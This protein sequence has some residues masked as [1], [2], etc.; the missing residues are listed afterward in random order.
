MVKDIESKEK[1]PTITKEMSDRVKSFDNLYSDDFSVFTSEGCVVSGHYSLGYLFATLARTLTDRKG[2]FDSVNDSKR[3]CGD[4][5]QWIVLD[6]DSFIVDIPLEGK[7]FVRF[8]NKNKRF[9]WILTHLWDAMSGV[10]TANKKVKGCYT[11]A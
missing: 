7:G 6:R 3:L 11:I 5:V 9:S 1:L 2:G 8:Y 10:M 4:G